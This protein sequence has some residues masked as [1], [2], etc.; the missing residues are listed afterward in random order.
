MKIVPTWL[1]TL[2]AFK[3]NKQFRDEYFAQDNK[4][5]IQ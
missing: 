5:K 1:R 3:M 4:S 2:I